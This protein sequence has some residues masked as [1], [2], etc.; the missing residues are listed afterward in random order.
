M[1][2]SK[3]KKIR[4]L[5]IGSEGFVGKA[6]CKYLEKIGEEAIHFDIKRNKNEDARF[7]KL[8][9]KKVDRVYFLAWEVGGAKYLYRDNTQLF[10]LNWN[11]DI[12]Q[13]VMSQLQEY[14]TSFIFVSSQLAEETDT[15]YGSTK[16]LG[17]LWTQQIKG[18]CARLWNVYGELE[19]STEKS[20]VAG[21]FVSQAV[22][23]GKIVMMTTGDEERQ[24]IHSDD[25]CEGLHY[26]LD[27]NLNESIYDLTS[28]EWTRVRDLAEHI[29]KN[30]KAKIIP[31]KQIGAVRRIAVVKGRPPGWLHKVTLAKGIRMMVD[32][33]KK[34]H[35]IK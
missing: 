20:H 27:N 35:K 23:T 11:L 2:T 31:G 17:E 25:V 15:I 5:V 29:G 19:E 10:Q 18:T 1:K 6:L 32:E 16:R 33:A 7:A 9:L 24:F 8:P 13:N 22:R 3:N 28:F 21:D 30:A 12:L 26:V 34:F 14:K 4:N